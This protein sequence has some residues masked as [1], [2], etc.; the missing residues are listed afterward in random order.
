LLLDL[1]LAGVDVGQLELI[2][3][4]ALGQRRLLGLEIAQRPISRRR[5]DG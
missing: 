4:R 5:L 3:D 1:Q 2:V